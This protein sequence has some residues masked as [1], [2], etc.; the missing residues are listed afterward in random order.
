[1]KSPRYLLLLASY[2]SSFSRCVLVVFETRKITGMEETTVYSKAYCTR[3]RITSGSLLH[4]EGQL[5]RGERRNR[6]EVERTIRRR[7]RT[8]KEQ[9]GILHLTFLRTNTPTGSLQDI[10][11]L[12]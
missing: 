4:V 11:F 5:A 10:G 8:K 3:A 6:H 1:M 2:R 9:H 12:S 7:Q